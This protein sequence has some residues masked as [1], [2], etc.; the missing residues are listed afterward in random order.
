V[1]SEFGD[2]NIFLYDEETGEETALTTDGSAPYEQWENSGPSLDGDRVVWSKRKPFTA[3]YDRDIVLLNLTTGVLQTITNADRDQIDPSLSG[4][5]IVWTDKR[6][7]PGGGDIY[8]FDIESGI[9]IP[10][11]TV[12]GLQQRP[13]ISGDTIVWMDYRDGRPAVYIYD[14]TSGATSRISRDF[15]VT[16]APLAS[17]DMIAWQEYSVF[18]QRDERAGSIVVYT[19]SSGAREVLPVSSSSPQLFDIDKNRILY[20]DPDNQSLKDGFVHLF[21]IDMVNESPVSQPS[22]PVSG[23]ENVTHV[24]DQPERSV[25]SQSVS[26][27]AIPLAIAFIGLLFW[28]RDHI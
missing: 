27:Y 20:A 3:A 16:D 19:I 12:Q 15:F 25:P 21:V 17:G 1:W 6:N 28:V 18:D 11:C 14:I 24:V 23:Q 8:L 22:L 5:R 4:S 26:S 9:E 7:E 2:N 13:K 10:V